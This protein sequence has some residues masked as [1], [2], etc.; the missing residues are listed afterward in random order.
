MR[1]QA[2]GRAGGSG[3]PFRQ[4]EDRP[5]TVTAR[6]EGRARERSTKERPDSEKR[7][8]GTTRKRTSAGGPG[9]V[10]Q[11]GVRLDTPESQSSWAHM[12]AS[13]MRTPP[14]QSQMAERPTRHT[15]RPPPSAAD[16]LRRLPTDGYSAARRDCLPVPLRYKG[17][18]NFNRQATFRQNL[19]HVREGVQPRS[20]PSPGE[21]PASAEDHL[22]IRKMKALLSKQCRTTRVDPL[23]SYQTNKSNTHASFGAWS[24]VHARARRA[25]RVAR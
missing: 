12:P 10:R 23:H 20:P 21:P 14:R 4:R 15:R 19:V 11:R 9:A 13:A 3:S 22:A 17:L 24:P 18:P 5:V 2:A 1:S 6:P 7:A 25:D 8:P 16:R